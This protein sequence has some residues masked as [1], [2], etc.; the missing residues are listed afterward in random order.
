MSRSERAAA[1]R[2]HLYTR[3]FSPVQEIADAVG[4]SLATIRRDL[5][6]LEGEGIV[7][8]AHGGAR[9]ASGA[10]TEIAF[11]IREER[12]LAEKRAIAAKAFELIKPHGAVFMDAATTVLQLARRL[13][14]EPLPLTVFTNGLVVAQELMDIPGVN[15]T[16]IGGRLRS[17]NASMIGAAAERMLE[18]FWFDLSFVGAGAIGDDARL[19]SIDEEEA[20]LNERMTARAERTVLLVDASKFGRRSTY[21]VRAID[22]RMTIITDDSLTPLWRKRLTEIGCPLTIAS[23][24]SERDGWSA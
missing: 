4:F 5:L 15:V 13:R 19:Y 1:I 11:A 18:S 7:E 6:V 22:E 2:Q 8:R 3:G 23:V 24:P 20:R 14:L 9:I 21:V 17:E 12:Q 16:V 10:G